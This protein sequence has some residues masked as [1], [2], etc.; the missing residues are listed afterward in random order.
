MNVDD[1][2]EWDKVIQQAEQVVGDDSDQDWQN[3]FDEAEDAVRR[4]IDRSME[5]DI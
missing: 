1:Q 4:E 5:D 2:Q 3:I